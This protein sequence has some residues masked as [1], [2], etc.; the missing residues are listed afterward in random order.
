MKSKNNAAKPAV[1]LEIHKAITHL[2]LDMTA[3]QKLLSEETSWLN[4][5][6]PLN[7]VVKS[8]T[9][10]RRMFSFGLEKVLGQQLRDVINTAV[11]TLWGEGEVTMH[12]ILDTKQKALKAIQAIENI[13]LLPERRLVD[14][15]YRGV[16]FMLKAVVGPK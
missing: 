3:V 13:N 2:V 9:L 10:G 5:A 8:S 6:S 14:M 16:H 7:A 15:M 12:G 4:V 11:E 1:F